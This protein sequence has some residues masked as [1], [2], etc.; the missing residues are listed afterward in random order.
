MAT[1]EDQVWQEVLAHWEDESAHQ[2]Y[3]TRFAD[4]DGLTQAG[5]RYSSVLE[6]KPNDPVAVRWREEIVK[7]ATV[8]GLALLPRTSPPAP[9]PRWVRPVAL[10][11]A[12]VFLVALVWLVASSLLRTLGHSLGVSP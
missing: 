12:A 9:A 10:F 4:L 11:L 1:L 5:R 2:A 8:Q 3:L 7:R 6:Q